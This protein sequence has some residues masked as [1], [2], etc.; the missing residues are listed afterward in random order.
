[1]LERWS[2]Q[3][4]F[5]PTNRSGTGGNV[6]EVLTLASDIAWMGWSWDLCSH[7]TC[8]EAAPGDTTIQDFN[9]RLCAGSPLPE[10]EPDSIKFGSLSCGHTNMGLRAIAAGV[11]SECPI[12]SEDGH[13]SI[14]RLKTRDFEFYKAVT[15]GLHWKV[16]RWTVRRDY[17]KALDVLQAMVPLLAAPPS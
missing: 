2:L 10:V 12:L 5:D 7:A 17:P 6:G 14:G 16:L 8:I 9:V 15:Q 3:V 1:M 4:G 11:A 13:F